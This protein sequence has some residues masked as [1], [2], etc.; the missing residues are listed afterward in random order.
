MEQLSW[1][2]LLGMVTFFTVRWLLTWNLS[3][4]NPQTIRFLFLQRL[5]A[6]YP[7]AIVV[8]DNEEQLLAQLQGR[9][10]KIRLEALYRRCRALPSLADQFAQEVVQTL[11]QALE[12]AVGLPADWR[13][14]ILVLFLRM[15]AHL[16][17]DIIRRPILGT[18]GVGYVLEVGEA[19]RWVTQQD[20]E[21]DSVSPEELHRVALRNL[22]RSCNRLVIETPVTAVEEDE[23]VVYFNTRDGFDAARLLVPSFY[24]RF[25]R[26]FAE[27]DLLVGIPTR[28]TLIMVGAL[29]QPHAELLAWRTG[30]DYAMQAFPLLDTLVRVTDAGL[31]S[32]SAHD[33]RQEP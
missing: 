7:D 18:L 6:R 11:Q 21:H 32:C 14:R 22:E 27:E 29:D 17:A 23:R 30:S 16:P 12:D 25:A 13:Q 4:R 26:R 9:T 3:P 5:L 33:D 28:D 8:A 1:I 31:E 10:C 20:L 24:Q 19:F 15:D 2:C